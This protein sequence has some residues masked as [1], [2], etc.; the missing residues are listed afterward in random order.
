M[1]ATKTSREKD[2]QLAE[3]RLAQNPQENIEGIQDTTMN[4]M[5]V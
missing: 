3:R 1:V 2:L 4:N 5:V